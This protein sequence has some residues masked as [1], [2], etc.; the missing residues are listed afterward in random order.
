MKV[1]GQDWM[2]AI[3]EDYENARNQA[4]GWKMK[5]TNLFNT[6]RDSLKKRYSSTVSKKLNALCEKYS[7]SDKRYWTVNNYSVSDG[8]N[9]S[10]T[11]P[12]IYP[13]VFAE[14]LLYIHEDDEVCRDE[15][16][17]NFNISD[18]DAALDRIGRMM[19]AGIK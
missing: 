9:Y 14:F 1:N 2:D 6:I 4:S 12:K 19:E 13:C 15:I 17:T 16:H 3:I 7:V 8:M 18:M 10:T 5:E 11:P